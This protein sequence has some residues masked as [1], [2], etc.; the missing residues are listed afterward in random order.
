MRGFIICSLQFFIT[1]IKTR[2]R[3]AWQVACMVNEKYKLNF[4][5]ETSK[6]GKDH[7]QDLGVYGWIILQ[8]ILE[9]LS[10]WVWTEFTWFRMGS[11][12]TF[13]YM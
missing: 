7:L 6:E 8:Y 11:D 12:G 13:L 5:W 1:E 3:W 10:V 2:M 4:C 9:K